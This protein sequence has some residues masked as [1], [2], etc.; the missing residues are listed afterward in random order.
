MRKILIVILFFLLA[1]VAAATGSKIKTYSSFRDF[2]KGES[3]G[4]SLRYDGVLQL[5]PAVQ[6][7]ARTELQQVWR[8]LRAGGSLWLAGGSPATL[9]RVDD[10]GEAHVAYTDESAQIFALCA[11]SG[12]DLYFAPS[13]GGVIYQYRNGRAEPFAEL[14]ADYVWDLYWQG[15]SLFAA[16]G[17]P[18]GIRRISAQGVAQ[19][20]FESDE[21]HI[22]SL[23]ADGKGGFYAGS[24][25]NGLVFH[26]DSRG[27]GF[28]LYD[29]RQTEVFAVLPDGRGGL[30]AA[31]ANERV[32]LP[33]S[34]GGTVSVASLVIEGKEDSSESNRTPATPSLRS[35]TKNGAL[36]HISANGVAENFWGRSYD[37]IQSLALDEGGRLLVGTG[38][39]GLVYAVSPQGD[40]SLLLDTEASQITRIEVAGKD[41]LLATSNQGGCLRVSSAA[42]KTGTYLSPVLDAEVRTGWGSLS[43]QGRG[44]VI[45]S[46][47]SGNSSTPDNTWSDWVRLRGDR[48]GSPISAP[49]ARF[50]QWRAE[51]RKGAEVAEVSIGYRQENAPP[52]IRSITVHAFGDAWLDAVAKGKRNK[53][54]DEEN[55][56]PRKGKKTRKQGYQS[57]S[58]D[59]DDPNEDALLF[60]LS[61]RGAGVRD[62]REMVTDYSGSVYS[63]DTRTMEDGRYRIRIIAS[64]EK[65]NTRATALR[66]E[67]ISEDILVDNTGPRI[68]SLRFQNG[69]VR[70][71]AEDAASR[72]GKAWYAIDAEEWQKLLP[73]DGIAD[74]PA[75]KFTIDVSHLK[76][77]EHTVTVKVH[78][79]RDNI[80]IRHLNFE[81]K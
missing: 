36:Y 19:A 10:D 62:W 28:V 67:K 48:Q 22:R 79:E 57:I 27:K 6:T 20:W 14:E 73:E 7:I 12:G 77:G 66:A 41:I 39:K 45:F 50:L 55:S 34:D 51:L 11:G 75:E 17:N 49:P 4:V 52:R 15:G 59:A 1:G 54:S 21:L 44:E 80:R 56:S 40:V 32:S 42:G 68:L 70:F 30:W 71:R 24:A 65:G 74:T 16:T 23:A 76:K 60:T 38:D 13:P 35:S 9:L 8:V 31:A 53:S 64:D 29:A 33:S 72:I 81:V 18:G 2:Q 26:V 47:R 61:Y 3:R 78:D 5:A 43:W 69:T 25:D 37:Q 46:V 63:W 58:W